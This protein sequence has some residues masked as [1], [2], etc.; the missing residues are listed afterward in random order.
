MWHGHVADPL[1]LMASAHVGVLPSVQPESFGLAVLEFMQCGVP[2]VAS[3]VAAPP[4]SL[5]TAPMVFLFRLTMP[6]NCTKLCRACARR[7][8]NVPLWGQCR[9]KGR[10][11]IFIPAVCRQDTR[12]I[13]SGY[14]CHLGLTA[15]ETKMLKQ[16]ILL[17]EGALR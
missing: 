7:R 14:R 15:V 3:S 4:K 16:I 13:R 1:P 11:K 9:A 8:Q 10:R 12:N 2:V 5:P 6:P 17:R